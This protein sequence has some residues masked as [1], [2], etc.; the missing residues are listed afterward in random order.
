MANHSLPQCFC[1]SERKFQITKVLQNKMLVILLAEYIFIFLFY[2]FQYSSRTFLY[3]YSFFILFVITI[4]S[5]HISHIP[6]LLFFF[7]FIMSYV[8]FFPCKFQQI[9]IS[10]PYSNAVTLWNKVFLDKLIIWH[11][12]PT[13]A[14]SRGSC[15]LSWATWIRPTRCFFENHCNMFLLSLPWFS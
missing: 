1:A 9:S 7:L 10:L 6:L 11:R 3:F 4:S 14:S 13:V 8:L 15:C 5:L 12:K 2:T